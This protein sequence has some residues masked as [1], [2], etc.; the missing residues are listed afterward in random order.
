MKI[1]IL[2]V[3]KIKEASYRDAVAE[4]AKRLSAYA[5]LNIIEVKDEKTREGASDRENDLVKASE[6]ARL[7]EHISESAYLIPLCIEGGEMS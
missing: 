6:A 4:Y 7:S 3:G 1:D 2:A 5:K